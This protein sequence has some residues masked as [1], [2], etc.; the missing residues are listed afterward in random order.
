MTNPAP[1][2]H[3]RGLFERGGRMRDDTDDPT[4]LSDLTHPPHHRAELV[5]AG[6][7]FAA[8]VVLAALWPWQTTWIDGPGWSRQPGLWPLIAVVGMLLF[9]TGE[10]ISCVLRNIRNGGGDVRAEVWLWV[11]AGEYVVWFLAYVL[12]TPWAGYLPATTIF[13]TLLAWRLGYR[14][15]LLALAPLIALLVVVVFKSLLSV[16]IPGGAVYDLLPQA[17]RNFLVIH[18]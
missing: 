7:S 11:K 3:R 4:D 15:R 14:G 10:L 8:A 16:H 9:G 6:A 12:A 17:L 2:D 18:L 13:M 5:Y 1:G